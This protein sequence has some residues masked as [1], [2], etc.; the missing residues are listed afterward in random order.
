MDLQIQRPRFVLFDYGETPA[1]EADYR[2]EAGFAAILSHAR[3]NPRGADAQA[4]LASFRACFHDLRRRAHAA[5]VEI[6]NRQRW[7]WLF[8]MYDLEFDLPA[9]ALERLY[10][11]AA[12][13]C[14]PTPGVEGLLERL[15]KRH[16]GSGVISNMGFAGDSLRSRLARLF[17]EHRFDFVLSSADYVLR[18]PDPRL[19]ELALHKCGHPAQEVW[20]LG[21]NPEADVVGAARA[22]CT[23]VYYERDLGCAYRELTQVESLPPCLRV[24]DWSELYPLFDESLPLS[25]L[26]LRS[27]ACYNGLEKEG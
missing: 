1:H 14:S 12:A 5:G 7:R 2:P 13:P 20:F 23:P 3:K 17:P 25:S 11:D 26:V 21:D 24:R 27:S 22:G 15:R 19:F 9:E 10:W 18:K 6:P 16:V 4:M 8:E